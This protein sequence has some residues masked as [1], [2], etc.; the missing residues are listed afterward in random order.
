MKVVAAIGIGIGIFIFISILRG[1]LSKPSISE[2][3]SIQLEGPKIPWAS[4]YA[5]RL[6]RGLVGVLALLVA[7]LTL[8]WFSVGFGM[9]LDPKS[10]ASGWR[11]TFYIL[12][13]LL[14]LLIVCWAAGALRDKVN[15]LYQNGA[16]T[17]ELLIAS[18]WH[19]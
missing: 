2:E 15:I 8:K 6:L 9:M 18:R 7:I 5:L 11:I 17:R 16:R 3:K 14:P 1:M 10:S 4:I 12:L 19:F 13:K